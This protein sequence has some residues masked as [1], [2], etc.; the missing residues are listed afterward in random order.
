[1]NV[2]DC[3]MLITGASRGLGRTLSV[4]FAG[5]GAK[6]VLAARSEEGLRETAD[7]VREHGVA[8]THYVCDLADCASLERLAADLADAGDAVDVLVNN[9]ADV[10]SRPLLDTSLEEI[11]RLVRTNMTGM[12]QLTRLLAPG[13]LERGRGMIV[14]ISSLAGYKPNPSQTVYSASKAGV[15]GI[16]LAL[17][18]EFRNTPIHVINVA[19]SSVGDAPGQ[20]PRAQYAQRLERAIAREEHELYLSPASKWLMRVYQLWP[21]LARMR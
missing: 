9:G 16:S 4:H 19:L 1:M 17:R 8:C 5:R 14:N 7:L 6:V 10:T 2:S 12:L 3:T 20:V 21:A 15:N 18:A 13:M 11:E